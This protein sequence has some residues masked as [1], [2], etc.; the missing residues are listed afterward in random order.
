VWVKPEIINA[1]KVFAALSE[2]GAPLEGLSV[3]DFTDEE[4]FFIIG[5]NPN[6][7]DILKKIP[8]LEFSGAYRNREI[9]TLKDVRASF[10]SL[11]DL[12]LAKE[13]S[14]RPQDIAD[15]EKLKKAKMS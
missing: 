7:I 12:I 15:V 2:F 9:F 10:L 6:R 3:E 8:G 1:H 4:S 11:D 14:A 13:A 5:I